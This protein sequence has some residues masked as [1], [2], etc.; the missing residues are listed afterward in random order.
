[1]VLALRLGR[2][3]PLHQGRVLG[4]C[5]PGP[6]LGP[7]SI[8]R[9]TTNPTANCRRLTTSLDEIT[10]NWPQMYGN[11]QTTGQIRHRKGIVG[12]AGSEKQFVASVSATYDLSHPRIGPTGRSVYRHKMENKG[13]TCKELMEL[14]ALKLTPLLTSNRSS[15]LEIM[16]M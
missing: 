13:C 15:L 4:L 14:V 8:R 7:R 16:G 6:R 2:P 10:G 11:C 3:G 9:I 12:I 5:W 1:M